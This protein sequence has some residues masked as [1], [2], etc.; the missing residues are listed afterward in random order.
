LKVLIADDDRISR[1]ILADTVRHMGHEVVLAGD[2]RQALQVLEAS[3]IQLAIVDWTMP[4]LDG[5]DVCA[6]VRAQERKSYL[7]LILVSARSRP[8]SVLEGLE[9]GADDYVAKPFSPVEVRARVRAA[10][11]VLKYQGEVASYRAYLDKIIANLDCGVMLSRES[12]VVFANEALARLAGIPQTHAVGRLR[13]ELLALHAVN[14]GD[15]RD[16]LAAMIEPHGEDVKVTLEVRVPDLRVLEWSSKVVRAG[17]PECRLDLCRDV[18]AEVAMARKLEEQATH[19]HLTGLLNRRGGEEI[20]AREV[21]RATRHATPISFLLIDIDHFKRV[22]DEH[23]HAVGDRVLAAVSRC[24]VKELR[25]YDHAIRWGGEEILVVLPE[26]SGF[27]AARVAER[28]RA[29][30]AALVIPDAPSVTVSIGLSELGLLTID[31]A[32]SAADQALYAAKRAGRN[33]VHRT[34]EENPTWPP[35][36]DPKIGYSNPPP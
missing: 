27:P 6:W 12:R 34:G 1:A 8:E 25:A 5:T 28:I 32:I 4:H 22:N 10:E 2:G 33:R 35:V 18:T 31:G 14:A 11:R 29:S 7:Y 13:D 30:V 19:D 3:D 21:A 24:I 16:F 26:T 9:K 15:A 20:I 23:G 17:A 36:G